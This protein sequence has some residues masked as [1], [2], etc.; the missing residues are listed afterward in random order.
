[1]SDNLKQ[2]RFLLRHGAHADFAANKIEKNE[3]A[4]AHDT[5]TVFVKKDDG[6][7]VEIRQNI[8]SATA[9]VPYNSD[10][11]HIIYVNAVVDGE[12]GI[13]LTNAAENSRQFFL[14]Q[15]G[16]K[17]R[18][19]NGPNTY[20]S[21]RNVTEKADNKK[22]SITGQNRSSTD[23]YPSVKAAADYCDA[24]VSD[25]KAYLGYT[26]SDI[27]GLCVDYEN[28]TFTRLA[29]A[30]GKNAGTDFDAFAMYGGRRRCNVADNGTVNAC[31]GDAGYTE[32]GSNGQVM[33][34]QP[35][36]WYKVVPIKL[37]K[38][39]AGHGYH[40]RKANYYISAAPKAGFKLHPLF[41]DANGN[42]VDHVLLSA[43]EGSMYDVSA[44][45]YIND[46]VN[47]SAAY[48]TGD[49][50]CSV[51]GQKPASS[52]ISGVSTRAKFETMASTR[53]TGWHLD[54][55][56]SVSACQLLMMIEFGTLNTQSAAGNGF[57]GFS[58][59]ST[60][61]CAPYT[62]STSSL[63]NA[64]G[65]AA[66]TTYYNHTQGQD[67]TGT[68]N[69]TTSVSYR[70]VENPWGS[71]WKYAQGV[72]VV[73]D[74]TTGG[75]QAYICDDFS[76]S[77]AALTEHYHPAGFSLSNTTGYISAMGYGSE[78]YDWVLMPSECENANNALP[79][80]DYGYVT[81][82]LNDLKIVMTGGAW[83]VGDKGGGFCV[84]ANTVATGT[85]SNKN[86]LNGRLLYVP[87][88]T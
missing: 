54:T 40:I 32:D 17:S 31:Y 7:V 39:T 64:T 14:G 45:A 63:G 57:I 55:I 60:Y 65:M 5:G 42:A 47:T 88:A 78:D 66:Q 84:A 81:A 16:I 26:D 18:A 44:S 46:S 8:D 30:V 86:K 12:T 56:Q 34:Y 1:M 41:Y 58:D 77:D 51:A 49:L 74:G 10:N 79:V 27:L 83:Y 9:S 62:G 61:N 24:S 75:G 35:A 28:K 72:N 59:N 85:N 25:V 33:V 71:I 11:C 68:T 76:F 15:S 2:A 82:N 87:S 73:G 23:F 80:G 29:G 3:M 37:D 70:G 52:K 19:K 43:Y 6:T 36:F 13:V 50:L 22:N 21:W 67:A 38:N 69:G 48:G 53:G 20:S 4:F